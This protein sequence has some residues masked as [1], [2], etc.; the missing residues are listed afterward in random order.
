MS[1]DITEKYGESLNCGDYHNN[2]GLG[3]LV[4]MLGN[5]SADHLSVLMLK[6][7]FS[8][9]HKKIGSTV[10]RLAER[11]LALTD[12]TVLCASEVTLSGVEVCELYGS[13]L[14]HNPEDEKIWGTGWKKGVIDYLTSAPTYSYLLEGDNA[15]ETAQAI[16]VYLRN[17]CSADNSQRSLVIENHCHV[18]D[19]EDLDMA[20]KILFLGGLSVNSL[21]ESQ[22]IA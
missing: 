10:Q 12:L 8:N 22:S 9:L 1:S 15:F 6:P 18:P 2:P 13:A 19:P 7:G 11:Q 5:F 4:E 20:L 3:Q 14:R 21:S 17:A 16:K